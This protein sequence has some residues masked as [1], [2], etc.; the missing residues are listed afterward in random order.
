MTLVTDIGRLLS[1]K[2]GLPM[3]SKFRGHFKFEKKIVQLLLN[4]NEP[5]CFGMLMLSV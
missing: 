3:D 2:T 5:E 1:L 4:V